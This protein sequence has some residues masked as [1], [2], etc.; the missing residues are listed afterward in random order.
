MNSQTRR[1]DKMMIFWLNIFLRRTWKLNIMANFCQDWYTAIIVL[2]L[3]Q[4]LKLAGSL[5]ELL[6]VIF[7]F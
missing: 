7:N 2:H 3:S 6:H 1:N 5:W 4:C